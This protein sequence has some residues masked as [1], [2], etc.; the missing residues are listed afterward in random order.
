MESWH[1]WQKIGAWEHHLRSERGTLYFSGWAR[2]QLEDGGYFF[3]NKFT[4]QNFVKKGERN[5]LAA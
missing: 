2:R 5:E 4:G 1:I 3:V